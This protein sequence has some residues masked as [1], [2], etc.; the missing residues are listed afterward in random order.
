VKGVVV[1]M[2][3]NPILKGVDHQEAVEADREATNGRE[4]SM[5]RAAQGSLASLRAI[6]RVNVEQAS[7]ILVAEADP[8]S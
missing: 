3:A 6:T 5:K 2:G 1:S 7:K 8:P 4:P